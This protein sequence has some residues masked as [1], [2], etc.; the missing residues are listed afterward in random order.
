MASLSNIRAAVQGFETGLEGERFVLSQNENG[1]PRLDRSP[2]F[3]KSTFSER[4]LL[5]SG[6]TV[7]RAHQVAIDTLSAYGNEPTSAPAGDLPSYFA[8]AESCIVLERERLRIIAAYQETVEIHQEWMDSLNPM[9]KILYAV[10]RFVMAFFTGLPKLAHYPK[11]ISKIQPLPVITGPSIATPGLV[12]NDTIPLVI[13]PTFESVVDGTS[14]GRP[15]QTLTFNSITTSGEERM[16]TVWY[17]FFGDF[18][19]AISYIERS[20]DFHQG[21]IIQAAAEILYH[22]DRSFLH[23]PLSFLRDLSLTE[24]TIIQYGFGID[25]RTDVAVLHHNKPPFAGPR[26]SPDKTSAAVFS[27]LEGPAISLEQRIKTNPVLSIE[28]SPFYVIPR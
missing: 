22:S 9:Q 17:D 28:R 12:Y 16:A 14:L 27:A 18:G 19:L 10:A 23:I 8:T 24:G 6:S 25:Q 13:R 1:T 3:S 15:S 20:Q 4:L 26:L 7:A 21:Y 5:T 2:D 11:T